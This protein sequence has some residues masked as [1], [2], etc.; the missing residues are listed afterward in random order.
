MKKLFARISHSLLLIKSL[1][2]SGRASF[3][4][5]KSPVALVRNS[6]ADVRDSFTLAR[7]PLQFT[8]IILDPTS[9]NQTFTLDA[10]YLIM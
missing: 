1:L 4:L 5:V 6:I 2:T 7:D 10:E 8:R 9:A 3:T